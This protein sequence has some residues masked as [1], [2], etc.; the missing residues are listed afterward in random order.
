M[1]D[2]PL[3]ASSIRHLL[4]ALAQIKLGL[5]QTK[6]LVERLGV[7]LT[8]LDNID[9]TRR[10]GDRTAHYL[11]AWL[12]IDIAPTWGKVVAALRL[13]RLKAKAKELAEMVG[14]DAKANISELPA[15]TETEI[16]RIISSFDLSDED[17]RRLFRSLD[18]SNSKLDDIDEGHV[19]TDRKSHYVK[20]WLE[21]ETEPTLDRIISALE[22]I[23]KR[24]EAETL[25]LE[26]LGAA[27]KVTAEEKMQ[28]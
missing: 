28:T 7:D 18:V 17:T 8:T 24:G 15:S 11:Q 14:V 26:A 6:S 16:L 27:V 9:A 5:T 22:V 2:G 23:G 19:G 1:A 25:K 13:M 21:I 10:G 4:N 20:A 12:D 3:S